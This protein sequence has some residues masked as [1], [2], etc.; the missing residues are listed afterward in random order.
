MSAQPATP[1]S[2]APGAAA[3][4]A[5]PPEPPP[6]PLRRS[7]ACVAA[8]VLL[9]CTQG[10]GMNLV[11]VNLGP[12]QGALGATANET[13]WLLAAYMAPNVS[14]SLI[15]T[16][17][18]NQ[19]G[20]RRFA[21]LSICVFVC[22][23]LL[24]LFVHDLHSAVAV[25][26][27]AGMAAAPVSTLGF[28]YMLDAFPPS[29]R[30]SWGLSLAITC[31][32]MGAPLARILSPTLFEIGQ[33]H[34]LY[35]L[36][37]G[38]ALMALAT[39]YLLPL[40][41][42]PHSKVLEKL[43]FV[44]Y[45]LLALGLGLLAVVLVL[46]R[47]Y[48]WF[49][50]SWIGACLAVAVLAIAAAV[51]IEVHRERPLINLRWLTSPEILHIAG[52]LLVFR[53]VLS[54]QTTGA[55]GLFQAL[56]LIN[57]QSRSLQAVILAASVAGGLLCGR[58][59]RPGRDAALHAAALGLICAGAFMDAHATG[60]TRPA[61]MYLS[62]AMIAFGGALFLPP[63]LL[64]GLTATLRQGPTYI[65]SFIAV[66]LVTQSLGGLMGSAL[67]GT[68]VTLREQFHS[69]HLV[70]HATAI[71]PW[72]VERVRL[73]SGAYGRVLTDR[74]L[75]AAEGVKLLSQQATQQA[76]V[77]A[78]ND[79]FLLVAVLAALALAGLLLHVLYLKFRRPCAVAPLAVS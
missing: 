25:R 32:L 38:L 21:E 37:M 45:P 30:M 34:G 31:S 70:E 22:A 78:Y 3:A 7:V 51:A 23:S 26:F 65:T 67:F 59:L 4:A 77:L 10:L 14:L 54:E 18:R 17:I 56:G 52:V 47:P 9:W 68:F 53:I 75:D 33:W 1:A 49:E 16:K 60:L 57:D 62:Q 29:S 28:L 66:F 73:L 50:A 58:L 64:T 43:D 20:L 48:W 42:I 19:Y 55:T 41:P 13:S 46:G 44:S 36:E 11:A 15:L 63:S 61:D 35:L 69:S 74:Q 5:P 24:H 2:G 40:T 6:I 39:V 12:L 79:A 71:D 72:T 8:S 76:T 27:L